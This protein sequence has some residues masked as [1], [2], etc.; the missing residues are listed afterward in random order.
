MFLMS[1][2]TGLSLMDVHLVMRARGHPMWVLVLVSPLAFCPPRCV[3]GCV[4]GFSWA[5]DDDARAL[6]GIGLKCQVGAA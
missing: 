6:A 4:V 1:P 5:K 2:Q 3:L